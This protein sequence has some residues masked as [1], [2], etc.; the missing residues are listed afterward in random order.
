[1]L[2]IREYWRYMQPDRIQSEQLEGREFQLVMF[3]C[4]VIFVLSVG[5]ALLMYPAVFS[6]RQFAPSTTP[7]V[8]FFGFCTLSCLLLG[9]IVDQQLKIRRLQRQIAMDRKRALLELSQA[10]ADLLVTMPNLTTFE[11]RLEMEFR[12]AAAAK[13]KMSVL[14]VTVNLRAAFSDESLRVAALGDAAKA[15]SRRLRE[16]DSIYNLRPGF[17][18]VILPGVDQTAA[19]RVCS[20]LVEGLADAAGADERFSF[21]V[22]SISYPHQT[23]SVHDLELA[24]S[25]WLAEDDAAQQLAGSSRTGD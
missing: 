17:F 23:S 15:I 2:M 20:R 12:R 16:Q 22:H 25:G 19:E 11:D 7:K 6:S 1:M 10:S 8:A 4:A 24:V 13:L 14:V 18:G 9:Y 3:V 21:Q 5:L